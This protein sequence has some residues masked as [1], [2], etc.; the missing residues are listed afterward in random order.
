MKKIFLLSLCIVAFS[1]GKKKVAI[2]QVADIS[3]GQCQFGLNSE[4]G[5]SLA[6]KV[7]DKAYFVDGFNIDDFGD[8]HDAHTGFC[9]VIRKGS[10]KGEIKN[11]R[12]MANTIKLIEE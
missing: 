2:E 11:S 5:C 9:N 8:A 6:V 1:C 12:F 3:C 4:D 10:I 7:F